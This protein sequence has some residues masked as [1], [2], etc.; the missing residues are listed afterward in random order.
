[1]STRSQLE[2][3]DGR[4]ASM[5]MV[6]E[7]LE[8][9]IERIELVT[10]V[11]EPNTGMSADAYHGL[12]KQVIAA[13]NERMAHLQQL[14]QFDAALSSGI[15]TEDL[16]GLVREWREQSQLELLDDITLTDAFEFIGPEDGLDQRLVRPAY[17]DGVTGRVIRI[18][19]VE[20]LTGS[21]KQVAEE[22]PEVQPSD[23]PASDETRGRASDIELGTEAVENSNSVPAGGVQ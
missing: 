1:V 5:E 22:E 14:M 9:S 17:V 3:L 23:P 19:I 8:R 2:S 4:V 15:S 6:L 18:G 12:R 20:R 21:E 11:R 13:V 7:K 10:V 16:T